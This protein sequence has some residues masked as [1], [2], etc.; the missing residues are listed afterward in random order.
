MF[1]VL[2]YIFFHRSELLNFCFFTTERFWY[3]LAMLTYKL[4][5]NRT[6]LP[7]GSRIG[8]EKL[9]QVYQFL[10]VLKILCPI[11]WYCP[12]MM[13]SCDAHLQ[14]TQHSNSPPAGVSNRC[15]KLGQVYQ[16]WTVS[17]NGSVLSNQSIV[18][19]TFAMCFFFQM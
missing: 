6:V 10:S 12:D 3:T 1:L 16:F 18:W 8:V 11:V 17:S 15:W 2:I 9:G 14:T 19:F 5:N 4:R 7:K 13:Y